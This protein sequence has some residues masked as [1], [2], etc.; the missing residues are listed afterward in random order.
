[1][2][3]C[4]NMLVC[5]A[6]FAIS[7]AVSSGCASRQPENDTE[8]VTVAS[9]QAACFQTRQVT[10]F[11]ALD[12][13]NLIVYAPTRSTAY[14]VRIQPSARELSFT[15]RIAFDSR[16]NRIC[17]HA[18]E[19]VIFDSD[20]M[21]RKYFVTDVYRLDAEGAQN[22]IDQFTAEVAVEAENSAGAEIDRDIQDDE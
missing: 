12:R 1:L 11:R 19:S 18:G 8:E 15:N 17:G 21:A 14:H 7:F 16:S 10:G 22:L 13:S 20:A 4:S 9:G 3:R 5:A 2:I 6:S